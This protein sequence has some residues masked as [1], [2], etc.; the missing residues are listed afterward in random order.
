MN[1]TASDFEEIL[2]KI[3]YNKVYEILEREDVM[4]RKV[5]TVAE[6]TDSG[7]KVYFSNDIKNASCVYP[8]KTGATLEVGNKVYV[9]H[10]FGKEGQGWIM[11]KA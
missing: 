7:A 9:Y 4:V 3:V 2:N 8:N 1:F 6:V 5:A 11:V 10:K